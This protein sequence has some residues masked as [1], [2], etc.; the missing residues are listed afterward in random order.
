MKWYS[1]RT[2]RELVA[3][4][5]EGYH[6]KEILA[7]GLERWLAVTKPQAEWDL[8]AYRLKM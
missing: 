1:E 4:E 3:K 7:E 5:L 2:G 6:P 8:E